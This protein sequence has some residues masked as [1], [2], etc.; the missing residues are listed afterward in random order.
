MRRIIFLLVELQGSA[1]M[2]GLDLVMSKSEEEHA[3][4]GASVT[5][6]TA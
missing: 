5:S 2:V 1:I 3:A 4:A 6:P